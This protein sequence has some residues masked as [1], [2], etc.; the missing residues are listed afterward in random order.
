MVMSWILNVLAK[1]IADRFS[2]DIQNS[3]HDHIIALQPFFK[4]WRSRLWFWKTTI[5]EAQLTLSRQSNQHCSFPRTKTC[6]I[7]RL[8]DQKRTWMVWWMKKESFCKVFLRK[9]HLLCCCFCHDQKQ[10]QNTNIEWTELKERSEQERPWSPRMNQEKQSRKGRKTLLWYH[11]RIVTNCSCKHW[12]E[13]Y[14][15]RIA[16]ER[17]NWLESD[18]EIQSQA[19]LM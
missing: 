10:P 16:E 3:R 7:E 12:E 18:D 5:N 8:R 13:F 15:S 11:V 6:S 2:Q 17:E 14:K 4:I 1:P 9:N 19:V